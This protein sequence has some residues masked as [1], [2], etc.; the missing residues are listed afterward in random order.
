[1]R[2]DELEFSGKW[3]KGDDVWLWIDEATGRELGYASFPLIPGRGRVLQRVWIEPAY[4]HQY[5]LT[6]AWHVW[7]E[8]YGQDFPIEEP[9]AAMQA[10]LAVEAS[11]GNDNPARRVVGGFHSE[12][13]AGRP[14]R[15][16]RCAIAH[17][18]AVKQTVICVVNDQLTLG[19]G[20]KRTGRRFAA[21]R[22]ASCR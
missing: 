19:S 11:D 4:R 13:C 14:S 17:Q 5:L 10:F 12:T 9:N 15:S 8:R 16:C 7:C 2:L 21:P 20:A 3:G 6:D 18:L 22:R 1:M